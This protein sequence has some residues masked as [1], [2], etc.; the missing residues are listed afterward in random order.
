MIRRIF[1]VSM[2]VGSVVSIGTDAKSTPVRFEADNGP[3][4]E[5]E[6][7]A[8]DG[9]TNA[10]DTMTYG[11][12]PSDTVALN[13]EHAGVLV[14]ALSFS[15]LEIEVSPQALSGVF[16]I[17][18]PYE[19]NFYEFALAYDNPG[20][21]SIADL[22]ELDST[23]YVDADRIRYR[24]GGTLSANG[25]HIPFA[26]FGSHGDCNYAVQSCTNHFLSGSPGASQLNLSL[27]PGSGDDT[28]IFIS[29]TPIGS[30][31]GVDYRLEFRVGL[32]NTTFYEVAAIPEPT[33]GVLLG[34]GLLGLASRRPVSARSAL[35]RP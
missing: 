19:L 23:D 8:T 10:I 17:G 33:T 32:G 18:L 22:T 4:V 12:S 5:V 1:A 2:L 11:L 34:L 13:G 9:I 14:E 28:K 29:T 35:G 21:A 7:F 20:G 15:S 25:Q 30:R 16:N 27:R 26:F 24:I 31:G 3:W 6:V